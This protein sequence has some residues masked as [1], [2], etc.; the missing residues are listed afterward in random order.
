MTLNFRSCAQRY[1]PSRFQLTIGC[2]VTDQFLNICKSAELGLSLWER[3]GGV[4]VNGEKLRGADMVN[5]R[6]REGMGDHSEPDRIQTIGGRW[7]GGT[8]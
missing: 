6:V 3:T 1:S 2:P 4:K 8:R 7:Y 5:P